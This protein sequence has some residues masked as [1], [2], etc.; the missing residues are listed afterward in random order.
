MY[1]HMVPFVL[2]EAGKDGVRVAPHGDEAVKVFQFESQITEREDE[3]SAVFKELRQQDPAIAL[4]A[5]I[6]LNDQVKKVA[7]Y[8]APYALGIEARKAAKEY[9]GR[10]KKLMNATYD[11]TLHD[12]LALETRNICDSSAMSLPCTSLRMSA[13]VIGAPSR[14]ANTGLLSAART[15]A[16][17]ASTAIK[18]ANSARCDSE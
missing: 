14:V 7:I 13:S 1:L 4:E 16:A 5:A 9:H 3:S 12:Q 18:A 8:E 6:K 10:L 17:D 2:K 11:N 15:A